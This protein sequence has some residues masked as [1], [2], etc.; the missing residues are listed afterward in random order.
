MQRMVVS[1]NST[2]SQCCLL[3]RTLG[4]FPVSARN[5]VPFKVIMVLETG[6]NDV[7]VTEVMDGLRAAEK[8][9]GVPNSISCPPM[10]TYSGKEV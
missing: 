5:F 6:L 3:M 2:A 1:L 7:G 10:D 9:M 4:S 8:R